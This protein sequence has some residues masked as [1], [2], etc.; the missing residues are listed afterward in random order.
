MHIMPDNSNLPEYSNINDLIKAVDAKRLEVLRC[1]E[2]LKRITER[3]SN[4]NRF[5]SENNVKH[6]AIK[7][8][9]N[10]LRVAAE[11]NLKSASESLITF[12]N[13]LLTDWKRALNETDPML[14]L[15]KLDSGFPILMMPLRIET[16]FVKVQNTNNQDVNQLWVRVFPDD[17]SIDTFEK[18]LSESEVKNA[19]DFR[20]EWLIAGEN[21]N[22]KRAAWRTLVD[23]HGAGRAQYIINKYSSYSVE[24]IPQQTE[25]A[26]GQPVVLAINM[27]KGPVGSNDR[28]QL[29]RYWIEIWRANGDVIRMQDAYADFNTEGGEDYKKYLIENFIPKNLNTDFS[30][31][32]NRD[33]VAVLIW[34]IDFPS[35]YENESGI[36]QNSW[37]HAPKVKILPERLRL[38]G[39]RNNV[40]KLNKVG[41]PIPVP[42][43]CGP[44]PQAKSE[45]LIDYLGGDLRISPEMKW[46]VDFQEAVSSGM[47]FIIDDS[48]DTDKNVIGGYDR[49]MVAG[50]RLTV[51][52]DTGREL[53]QEL[54][55]D[56]YNSNSGFSFLK[57]GTPTNNV[58][59]ETESGY[60]EAE[61][62]DESFDQ[63][64]KP[65][66]D[67]LPEYA[68]SWYSK[69]DRYWF[70]EFL[71][72]NSDFLENTINTNGFDQRETRAMNV[73]LWPATWGY[74]FNTMMRPV[75]KDDEIE[76][77]KKYFNGCVS[78]RGILPS[79]RIGS[80]PYGILPTTVFSRLNWFNS[81]IISYLP[82][83]IKLP[84]SFYDQ[85]YSKL[86]IIQNHWKSMLSSVPH[87]RMNGDS[88][89][90]MLDILGQDGGSVEFHNRFTQGLNHLWNL[91][92]LSNE[93]YKDGDK[94]YSNKLVALQ[95][96]LKAQRNSSAGKN[97]L[98]Q[99]GYTED[100]I[101][102]ILE[103]FFSAKSPE[104]I[105]LVDDKPLSEI[106]PIR[107]YSKT[108][109]NV[110][111]NYIEW[112]IEASKISLDT[113]KNQSN[114]NEIPKSL[115][116]IMLRHSLQLGFFT[117][118]I[119]LYKSKGYITEEMWRYI[120][121]EPDFIH[122]RDKRNASTEKPAEG[123]S[124]KLIDSPLASESRYFLLSQKS[125]EIT[126]VSDKTIADYI[127]GLLQNNTAQ[128]IYVQEQ[129]KAL[130]HLKDIPTARLERLLTEHIDCASYR[131]DAWKWGLVNTQ[132]LALREKQAQIN[133][134][135]PGG[136][137]VGAYGWLEN[138]KT[139][140]KTLTAL[141]TLGSNELDSYFKPASGA[142][143]VKDDKNYGY[144]QAPSLNH[145]VTA[146]ILRNTYLS[147]ASADNAN[148]F[149]INLSSERV[150]KALTI[151]EGIQA[152]QNLAALLG[153]QFERYIHDNNTENVDQYIF[154]LRRQFPLV[155]DQMASTHTE[156]QDYTNAPIEALEARNV[157]N[158]SDLIA[159]VEARLGPNGEPNYFNQLNLGK[160][161]Q[162][163]GNIIID[164]INTIRDLD[165]AVAD[166]GIAESVHQ[167]VQGNIDRAA[168]TLETYS[169]GNY[170]QLPDVIQTPRSGVNITHRVGIHINPV[171]LAKNGDN[172]RAKAEPG[173]N[174]WLTKVLPL[175]GNI[176]VYAK[177]TNL[178]IGLNDENVCVSM[179]D[180]GLQ[181][182]DL[183]YL[184][185]DE[186]DQAMTNLDDRILHWVM[187]NYLIGAGNNEKPRPDT[188]IEI[189]YYVKEK[190]SADVSK[191]SVFEI[192]PLIRH[193]RAILLRSRPLRPT[194][195]ALPNE[196]KK[197]SDSNAFLDSN[198]IKSVLEYINLIYSF[199]I[200]TT[201]ETG[202]LESLRINVNNLLTKSDDEI[203]SGIDN[204][205]TRL[206]TILK[207][208]SNTGI[209]QTGFGFIYD[210]QKQQLGAILK[211]IR[212]IL[213]RWDKKIAD[214]ND[215]VQNY[216]QAT[217]DSEKLRFLMKAERA[218]STQPSLNPDLATFYNDILLV[219]LHDFNIRK[220]LLQ[221]YVEMNH[222]S[223]AN[224]IYNLGNPS[225]LSSTEFDLVP[226]NIDDIKN[227]CILYVHDIL[228]KINLLK[229]DLKKRIIR[230]GDLMKVYE[231]TDQY[232]IPV[233]TL[234]EISKLLLSEDFKTIPSFRM[235]D[236]KHQEW[237]KAINKIDDLLKFQKTVKENP[238]PVDDWFYGIARVREKM[239]HF[240]QVIFW[241][242]GFGDISF[243]LT[244]IQLPYKQPYC[245][246]ALEFGDEDETLNK[247]AIK[248]FRENDH[249]LYTAYYQMPFDIN[250]PA[251]CGLLIDEWT[252]V[253]P[254][255]T[256]N[257]GTAFHYDRP[258]SEPPQ[259]ML[260]VTSPQLNENWKWEDLVDALNET[261]DE[262]KLRGVE[263]KQIDNTGFAAF[264]PATVS[265]VTRHAITISANYSL[266]SILYKSN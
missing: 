160:I 216:Q 234:Q 148:V 253:V 146:S 144:I 12:E 16:R 86:L 150:R 73:A 59:E 1:K 183:L 141:P 76:Y 40:L 134:Q 17:C 210:W 99:M 46:M 9:L 225:I 26:E 52:K 129:I 20:I 13:T 61:D 192:I 41:N 264:L 174:E 24:E 215:S 25:G 166:L 193:L 231:E 237:G 157:L 136:L 165:D 240:E 168:G 197:Q 65:E 232:G 196:S 219:K 143:I 107:E 14:H 212:A 101:P 265:S 138:V 230:C 190:L 180:L 81:K 58:R 85:L 198:R 67:I 247:E 15:N 75:F 70:N 57:V 95:A 186:A 235:S 68:L 222:S 23:N 217:D 179:Q 7:A 209:P 229:D 263:P 90:I 155:S 112:L 203:I 158:G 50:V 239:S 83:E 98:S 257:T 191:I 211:K 113:I 208:L 125:S 151:I 31:V 159:F 250:N 3:E 233:D 39:Y 246:Y 241:A 34:F 228:T 221:K 71:G 248:I 36:Q 153:Y 199:N 56:H 105:N 260:L 104:L 60:T 245:W 195:I 224:A 69:P 124:Q 162:A 38:L 79:V 171:A 227:A 102:E 119:D 254:T 213:E 116:Y 44:D 175:P 176:I 251:K 122:I 10:G 145:A 259:T 258:N 205:S 182:I 118:A 42:L 142:P 188:K 96:Y 80:Q 137:Y 164:A 178:D 35:D 97:I 204:I 47:G 133:P 18:M 132:L 167:V 63:M 218:I 154:A 127:S 11:T 115:L 207:K 120:W 82:D 121:S 93:E 8:E 53:V 252:E 100:Q 89:Q 184:I 181:P 169:K 22:G 91:Y 256:E 147:R 92:L 187:E 163:G 242:E 33:E 55:E 177:L 226:T 62:A 4:L 170:P 48:D 244:P 32:E 223:I 74:F 194:D 255:G 6:T 261:L 173:L 103:K 77:L 21:E 49:I 64:F 189:I 88:H 214:Y 27:S 202:E 266:S 117:T 126:G 236:E 28:Q 243:D 43:V 87:I 172:P 149:S 45:D 29:A 5:F 66:E 19:Q 108:T 94:I 110:S 54:F 156:E 130:E 238:L 185:N 128:G 201:A 51:D 131:F 84:Y 152:G 123:L 106:L 262:A 37:T 78:G 109:G 111:L 139:E 249:L 30:T 135:T 140:D 114:L 2:Q 200:S 220:G 206:I 72:F 161:N